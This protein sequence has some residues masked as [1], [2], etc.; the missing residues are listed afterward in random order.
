MNKNKR[1]CAGESSSF[2]YPSRKL[3]QHHTIKSDT[4]FSH[5]INFHFKRFVVVVVGDKE[6][7]MYL[8]HK[9]ATI[10]DVCWMDGKLKRLDSSVIYLLL[11]LSKH[12][13]IQSCN[14]PEPSNER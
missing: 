7:H 5:C 3:L 1:W 11:L 4:W 12:Q 6:R 9:L 13:A 10:S 8:A 2:I 14:Q